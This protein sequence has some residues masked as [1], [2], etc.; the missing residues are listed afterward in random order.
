[1]SSGMETLAPASG[2][3]SCTGQLQKYTNT[4]SPTSLTDAQR[5]KHRKLA[6]TMHHADD[7]NR[8]RLPGV[9]DDILVEIPEAIFPAEKLIVIMADARILH[10]LLQLR[11][12]LSPNPLGGI[13][14]ILGDVE[15]DGAEVALSFRREN[16]LPLQRLPSLSTAAFFNHCAKFVE[17]LVAVEHIASFGL[18]RTPL[19]SHLKFLECLV[20]LL[21][22]PLQEAQRFAHHFAGGLVAARL[23]PA[24]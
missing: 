2:S 18:F 13:W 10:E 5:Q 4:R 21:L 6:R 14:A 22:L 11:I 3:I 12:E 24:L 16:K 15:Q 17:D 1:M 7:L 19:Q 23:D 9:G 8:L 20:A